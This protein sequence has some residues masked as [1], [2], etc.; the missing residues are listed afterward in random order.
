MSPAI[1][2]VAPS[3]TLPLSSRRPSVSFG[4]FG[5]R[6]EKSVCRQ[7]KMRK[8]ILYKRE[9]ELP[10][11]RTR[12]LRVTLGSARGVAAASSPSSSTSSVWTGPRPWPWVARA[13][14]AGRGESW[15]PGWPWRAP[16]ASEAG[17]RDSRATG[18]S[19]PTLGNRSTG[20]TG[21]FSGRG[22]EAISKTAPEEAVIG[23]F[24]IDG[25]GDLFLRV[26]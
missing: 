24:Q 25:L 19:G 11:F 13:G 7:T 18:D 23:K 16:G 1:S 15:W 26:A 14:P 10:P 6:G 17:G 5:V 20:R 22:P 3:P 9:L 21:F 2:P 8:P 12:P 4:G